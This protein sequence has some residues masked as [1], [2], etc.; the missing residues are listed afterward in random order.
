M[1][2][3]DDGP[4]KRAVAP[5]RNP[6]M[7]RGRATEM[8]TRRNEKCVTGLISGAA[9]ALLLAWA[10]GARAE[11]ITPT[12][13]QESVLTRS[14]G[15]TIDVHADVSG[16]EA[17]DDVSRMNA[18]PPLTHLTA[19]HILVLK[20]MDLQTGMPMAYLLVAFFNQG[21]L[22]ASGKARIEEVNGLLTLPGEDM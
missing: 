18:R 17:L 6:N 14:Q 20:A 21:C 7:H 2:K 5:D 9:L 4:R 13:W 10:S 3:Q 12:Q 19:D 1:T 22:A 15:V 8:M 16:Q 11:C